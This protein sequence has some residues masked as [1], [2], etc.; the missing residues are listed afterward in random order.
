[1]EKSLAF[2]YTSPALEWIIVSVTNVVE[3]KALGSHNYK[4]MILL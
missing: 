3:I 2:S 1:M 4:K